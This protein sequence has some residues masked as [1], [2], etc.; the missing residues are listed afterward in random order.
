MAVTFLVDRTWEAF[1]KTVV[2]AVERVYVDHLEEEDLV[3][4]WG[5]GTGWI[6]EMTRKG[7]KYDELLD[8]IQ[9][10]AEKSGLS[11]LY[12]NIG[13][14]LAALSKVDDTYSKW[15]IVLTDL[16]DLNNQN[17]SDARRVVTKQLIPQLKKI[18]SFNL[19]IIDASRIGRWKPEHPMWPHWEEHSKELT[20]AAQN[21]PGCRGFNI[22]ADNTDAISEAFERVAAL[23][24][25]GGV[26]DDA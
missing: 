14:V 2:E 19:V 16:V 7:D 6:F 12:D 9:N 15:L 26:A 23:M 20:K 25:S 17:E 1:L 8:M 24:Q 11:H 5:L 4:Y 22:G 3:G 18:K 13:K 21:T 10:S